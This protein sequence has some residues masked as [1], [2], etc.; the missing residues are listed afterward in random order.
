MAGIV[1]PNRFVRQPQYPV[2]LDPYW[3]RR[4][5]FASI[6]GLHGGRDLVSK[7]R[8]VPGGTIAARPTVKGVAS[9][10]GSVAD[11]LVWSS[12]YI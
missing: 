7:Q 4:I 10:T 3:E 6:S 2:T 5:A 8:P 1:L 12:R 9:Y 11:G